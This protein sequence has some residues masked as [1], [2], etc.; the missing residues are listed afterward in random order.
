MVSVTANVKCSFIL[1]ATSGEQSY[2]FVNLHQIA[3]QEQ[4]ISR[5]PSNVGKVEWL[6]EERIQT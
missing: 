2:S 5:L 4:W 3:S 1:T 6:T